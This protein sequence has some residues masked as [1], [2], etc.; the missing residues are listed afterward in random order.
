MATTDRG[1]EPVK[2]VLLGA[3][4][5][6]AGHVTRQLIEHDHEVVGY[7][8]CEPRASLADVVRI[9]PSTTDLPVAIGGDRPD[10]VINMANLYTRQADVGTV[11]RLVE[12]NS[13]L[14]SIVAEA[15]L[16]TGSRLLH[17]GSAWQADVSTGSLGLDEAP[18]YSLHRGVASS[19]GRWY[20]M[21]R[22]LDFTELA[23]ADTYGPDDPRGKLITQMLA[24]ARTGA[25]EFAL[26]SQDPTLY[27]VHVDDVAQ[28]VANAVSAPHPGTQQP[29]LCA[30]QPGIL[31]SQIATIINDLYGVV[32]VPRFGSRS[33]RPELNPND[34]SCLPDW[35]PSI[36]PRDGL[37]LLGE[38]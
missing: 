4:G 35:E 13:L 6:L 19:I 29:W 28:C 33:P 5:Y 2:I 21:H 24:L 9:V 22:G 37:R 27:P 15:C 26:G 3:S 32:I 16:Q 12:V 18:I 38:G 14:M 20:R 1:T 34:F 10:L 11:A 31:V 8:R 7:H 25:A 17:I 30:W 23:V 36:S